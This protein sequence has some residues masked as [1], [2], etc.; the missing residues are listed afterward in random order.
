MRLTEVK[1]KSEKPAICDFHNFWFF[2]MLNT[3][4]SGGTNEFSLFYDL[5]KIY[6]KFFGSVRLFSRRVFL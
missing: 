3:F 1:K 2:E 4:W 6:F 5:E